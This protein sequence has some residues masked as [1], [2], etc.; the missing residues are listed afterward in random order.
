MGGFY[1]EPEAIKAQ[2]VAAYTCEI[3]EQ[4]KPRL[5]AFA[6]FSPGHDAELAVYEAVGE[7]LG[8]KVID[9]EQQDSGALTRVVCYTTYFAMS[10]GVTADNDKV[11]WASLPYLVSVKAPNERRRSRTSKPPSP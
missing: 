3:Y 8:V 4:S 7:V 9:T 6:P 1:S 5:P 10:C 11:N 2:A